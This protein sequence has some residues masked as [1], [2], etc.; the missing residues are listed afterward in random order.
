MERLFN[1]VLM[2]GGAGYCGARLVPQLLAHGYNVAVP[3]V[4]TAYVIPA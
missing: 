3:R 4:A 1:N 2:T